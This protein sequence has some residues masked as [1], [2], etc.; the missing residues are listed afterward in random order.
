LTS[1]PHTKNM[2]SKDLLL[3]DLDR[4][5]VKLQTDKNKIIYIYNLTDPIHF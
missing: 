3:V 5:S 4:G 1:V 2:T